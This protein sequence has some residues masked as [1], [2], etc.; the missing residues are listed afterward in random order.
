MFASL[1]VLATSL[2]IK[3]T[4]ATESHRFPHAIISERQF[5]D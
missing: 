5:R 1:A 3:R 2:Q 4:R